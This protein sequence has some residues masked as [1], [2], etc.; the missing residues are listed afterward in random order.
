[1]NSPHPLSTWPPLLAAW[2]FKHFLY[3]TLDAA[4]LGRSCGGAAGALKFDLLAIVVAALGVTI[5]GVGV[6]SGS[7][8]D[9]SRV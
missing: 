1:M 9:L 5:T 6:G 3:L 7:L 8:L 4:V 2:F